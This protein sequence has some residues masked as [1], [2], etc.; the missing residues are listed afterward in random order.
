MKK[1][2]RGRPSG[3]MIVAIIA[4]VVALSGTAVAA[5]KLGLSA[6]SKGAKNK[7][8][9]VGKLTYVSTTKTIPGGGVPDGI[10]HPVSATCPSGLHVIGGG[11]KVP[12]PAPSSPG[13]DDIFIQ[14]SYPT[15]TGWAGR[16]ANYASADNQAIATTTAICAVSRVVT[17]APPAS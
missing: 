1:V 12:H 3:A 17:G 10:N 2:L 5:K 9:G 4:L 15:T 7:T 6:L 11:I 16:V 13:E 8:V 14:D